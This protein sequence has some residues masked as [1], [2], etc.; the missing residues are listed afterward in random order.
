MSTWKSQA[1]YPPNDPS[2][3]GGDLRPAL[4]KGASFVSKLSSD[5]SLEDEDES[6]GEALSCKKCGGKD[7]RARKIAGKGQKLVCT[8]CGTTAE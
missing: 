4:E 7:F 8:R 2:K 5:G 3:L 6:D 1:N